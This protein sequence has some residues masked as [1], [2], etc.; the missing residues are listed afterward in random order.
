MP[1]VA[2][3]DGIKAQVR[4]RLSRTAFHVVAAES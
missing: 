1:T 3:I 2:V 4:R